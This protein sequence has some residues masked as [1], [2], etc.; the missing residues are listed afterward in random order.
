VESVGVCDMCE[1][2]AIARKQTGNRPAR[3]THARHRRARIGRRRERARRMASHITAM[4]P[5]SLG[6]RDARDGWSG[7]LVLFGPRQPR[8]QR[9]MWWVPALSNVAVVDPRASRLRQQQQQQQQPRLCPGS[10]AHGGPVGRASDNPRLGLTDRSRA[11]SMDD[12]A[13][14]AGRGSAL[15]C[16][17]RVIISLAQHIARCPALFRFTTSQLHNDKKKSASEP[18]PAHLQPL[19]VVSRRWTRHLLFFFLCYIS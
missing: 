17:Y 11:G 14:E 2:V 18:R 3:R 15:L 19:F 8:C 1:G 9:A 13:R 6:P 16:V 10:G 5:P 7:G 12:I 4:A